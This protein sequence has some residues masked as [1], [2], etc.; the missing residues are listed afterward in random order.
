MLARSAGEF[1]WTSMTSTPRGSFRPRRFASA[2]SIVVGMPLTPKRCGGAAC[3]P[4]LVAGDRAEHRR[5]RDDEADAARV[6]HDRGRDA[7]DAAL[8]VDQ[9]AAGV[10]GVDRRVRLDQVAH[11]LA[12]AHRQR[13]AGGADDAGGHRPAQAEGVADRDDQ[14]THLHRRRD[15]L[16]DRQRQVRPRYQAQDGDIDRRVGELDHRGKAASVAED[17][18]DRVR[19]R[20]LHDVGVGDRPAVRVEDHAGACRLRLVAT[21]WASWSRSSTFRPSTL[22]AAAFPLRPRRRFALDLDLDDGGANPLGSA[23]DGYRVGVHGVCFDSVV[24]YP[25]SFQL[26]EQ[27]LFHPRQARMGA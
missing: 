4:L 8:R 22:G 25:V 21:F 13:T 26:L 16:G 10:A 3:T 6:G 23:G 9:R 18:A 15:Q 1:A 2:A 19:L 7:D 11:L 12:G 14:L 27:L 17:G 5:R 24:S 20:A